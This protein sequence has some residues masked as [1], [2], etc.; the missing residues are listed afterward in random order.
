MKKVNFIVK[1]GNQICSGEH[2]GVIQ[3]FDYNA[4]IPETYIIQNHEQN[5]YADHLNM[6][7]KP[8]KYGHWLYS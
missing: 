8:P 1:E 3:M 5:D 6:D 4:Y 2:F 7:K